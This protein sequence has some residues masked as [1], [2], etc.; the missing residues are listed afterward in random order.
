M[1]GIGNL[2]RSGYCCV[3]CMCERDGRAVFLDVCVVGLATTSAAAERCCGRVGWGGWQCRC[4]SNCMSPKDGRLRAG[5]VRNRKKKRNKL[6]HAAAPPHLR[7]ARRGRKNFVHIRNVREGRRTA[8]RWQRWRAAIAPERGYLAVPLEINS[9]HPA[10]G[11]PPSAQASGVQAPNFTPPRP[12]APPGCAR[13]PR[14]PM[15][16][17]TSYSRPRPIPCLTLTRPPGRK[18]P[19]PVRFL[20][21]GAA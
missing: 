20:Q 3:G 5:R 18:A 16:R 7:G 9:T 12:P 19:G 15:P 2:A 10:P 4:V 17:G 13:R 1:F 21:R 6:H 11:G 8:A 14:R